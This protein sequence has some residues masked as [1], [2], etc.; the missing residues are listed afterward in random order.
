[1]ARQRL[2]ASRQ[3]ANDPGIMLGFAC[4]AES[5]IEKR[6]QKLAHIVGKFMTEY[7]R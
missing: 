5:E 1:M 4:A 7:R 3:L 6:V 2:P